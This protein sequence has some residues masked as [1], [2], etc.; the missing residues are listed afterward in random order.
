MHT[1]ECF[2]L[3]IDLIG[4]EVQNVSEGDEVKHIQVLGVLLAIRFQVNE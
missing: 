4:F 3:F 1:F 2:K